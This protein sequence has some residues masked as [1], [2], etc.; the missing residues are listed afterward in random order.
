MTDTAKTFDP[1]IIP[2]R[3]VLV[4]CGGTGAQWARGIARLVYKL[5]C[6][7]KR[8]PRIHFVD[9]DVVELKNV[10]RQL[11]APGDVGHHK[12]AVLAQRFN[13]AYGLDIRW[14]AAPVT[15]EHLQGSRSIVCGA[16]DNAAARRVIAEA[17]PALWIDAG[18]HRSSG[19]VIIGS[20]GDR[21]AIEREL[22]KSDATCRHLPYPSLVFPELLEPEAPA[23][24]DLSCAE[25]IAANEQSLL[26]NDFMAAVGTQYLAKVLLREP[27]QSFVTFV[28]IDTL[29]MRS[30]P[31]TQANLAAYIE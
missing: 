16:V 26:V 4:G 2:E 10:G 9:P 11:F 29:G 18:N 12:A 5:K 30:L 15:V 17:Q 22:S 21:A 25:L 13:Y 7:N 6:E 24:A 31:I 19:Q 20:T 27:I 3:V 1:W 8:V 23:D 28:D 14:T